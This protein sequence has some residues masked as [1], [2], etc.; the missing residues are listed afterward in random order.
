MQQIS[1]VA[2]TSFRRKDTKDSLTRAQ[3]L[4][5]GTNKNNLPTSAK[6]FYRDG[7]EY[8]SQQ[9]KSNLFS[10]METERKCRPDL[11][12]KLAESNQREETTLRENQ[13]PNCQS[14]KL[15]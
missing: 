1:A 14:T 9:T 11:K 4:T 6:S 10:E 2:S 8:S 7:N 3:E 5:S 13:H 12:M 15:N